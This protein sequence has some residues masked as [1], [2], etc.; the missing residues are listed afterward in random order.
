MTKLYVGQRVRI[1]CANS[2]LTTGS[3]APYPFWYEQ[4]VPI[5]VVGDYERFYVVRTLPHTKPGGSF[6]PAWPYTVTI[7]KF[8]I[9]SNIMIVD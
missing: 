2:N 4:F 9:E 6:G 7:D 1:R 5:E 8:H 3:T